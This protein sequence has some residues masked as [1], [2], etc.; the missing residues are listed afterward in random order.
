MSIFSPI[1][2]TGERLEGLATL[3]QAMPD[4]DEPTRADNALMFAFAVVSAP[5]VALGALAAMA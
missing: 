4:E 5:A 2:S 3:D 1:A